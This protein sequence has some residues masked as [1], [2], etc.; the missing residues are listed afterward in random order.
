[1]ATIDISELAPKEAR[2]FEDGELVGEMFRD[3]SAFEEQPAFYTVQLS[4]DP[5]GPRRV[6]AREQL[7]ET[8]QWTVDS[9]PLL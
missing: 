7:L 1:M 5:R 8:A 4:E 2:I 6:Y 3:E 9:H